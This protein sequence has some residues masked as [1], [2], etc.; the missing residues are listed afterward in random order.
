MRRHPAPVV[1]PPLAQRDPSDP[2]RRAVE[3]AQ[4]GQMILDVA[5]ADLEAA[6]AHLG[7]FHPSAWHVAP[8]LAEARRAWDRLRAEFGSRVLKAALEQPPITLLTI[9]DHLPDGPRAI[10]IPIAGQTYRVERIAGTP[11]AP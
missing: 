1:A 9:G 7:P 2:A 5:A 11:I 6:E 4:R 8:A 3:L 10:F